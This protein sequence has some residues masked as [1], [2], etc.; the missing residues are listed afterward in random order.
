MKKVPYSVIGLMMLFSLSINAQSIDQKVEAL[1]SKMTLEE[2]VGQMNQYNGFWNATGPAP[3]DGNAKQKYDHLRTGMV[4][5]V[6]NVRGAEEYAR[7]K[8]SLSMNLA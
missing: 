8:N 4:G 3:T 7:C 5:S 6:L 1:L 2:K